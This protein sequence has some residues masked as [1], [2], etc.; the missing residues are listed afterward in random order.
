MLGAEELLAVEEDRLA[1]CAGV[2]P[3]ELTLS[4]SIIDEVEH[5]KNVQYKVIVS[6]RARQMLAAMSFLRRKSL[7]PAEQK[8]LMD[9]IRSLQLCR[10]VFCFG[11]GIYTAE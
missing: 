9:A 8:E 4:D 5:E 1:G 2:T 7:L 3:D 11:C 6:D 10:S